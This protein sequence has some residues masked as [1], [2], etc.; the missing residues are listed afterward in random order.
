MK[1]LALIL[2]EVLAYFLLKRIFKK[3]KLKKLQKFLIPGLILLIPLTFGFVLLHDTFQPDNQCL[4]IHSAESKPPLS[5][6]TAREYLTQGNYDYDRGDCGKAVLDYTKAVELNQNYAEAYNN[7]AYTYM[8]MR[9]YALAIPDLNRAIEIR[10]DYVH[11]LINRGDIY[12]F[13]YD[14]D[15]QKAISDYNKAISLG[16]TQNETSVCGHRAVAKYGWHLW[17]FISIFRET[18]TPEC[19]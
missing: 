4:F 3:T 5:L 15:K 18:A 1:V 6:E 11:A 7:R 19:K 2:L 16:A 12:N 14:I 8:R 9:A 17:T 10:P 13:Y